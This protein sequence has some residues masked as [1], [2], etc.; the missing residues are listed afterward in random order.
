MR[1]AVGD[2]GYSRIRAFFAVIHREVSGMSE[3][4]HP[5]RV[6]IVDADNPLQEIHGE[7]FWREDH[8]RILSAERQTSYWDGYNE[9]RTAAERGQPTT[10]LVRSA[11]PGLI[12]RATVRMLVLLAIVAFAIDVFLPALTHIV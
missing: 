12:R 8:E 10:V 1:L 2:H 4:T 7:F 3:S 5:K 6:V 9:G 11:R